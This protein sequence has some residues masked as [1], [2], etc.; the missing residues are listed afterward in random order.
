M[1][2]VWSTASSGCC[3][4][5]FP[6][7]ISPSA[8][9]RRPR[10]TIAATDGERQGSGVASWT[11]LFKV[12]REMSRWST[13]LSFAF[14]NTVRRQKGGSRSLFVLLPRRPPD[15]NPRGRRQARSANQTQADCGP[16]RRYHQRARDDRPLPQGALLLADKGYVS[17]FCARL[18]RT[19]TPGPTFRPI[20]SQRPN[21]LQ[22]ASLPGAQPR[23]AVL[24]QDQARQ[25]HRHAL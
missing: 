5:E 3:A 24:Q 2:G 7:R 4:R 16:G 15:Q 17:K 6:G 25:A 14:T 22:Q 13:V 1:T 19:E 23:G 12:M 11:R 10:S 21:L 9:A 20:Q 8:K 18:S